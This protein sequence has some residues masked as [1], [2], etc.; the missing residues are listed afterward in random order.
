MDHTVPDTNDAKQQTATF[1]WGTDRAVPHRH[2][3][4]CVSLMARTVSVA[5]CG[6]LGGARAVLATGAPTSLCLHM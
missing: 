1:T 2:F 6:G 3:S 4:E 5:V